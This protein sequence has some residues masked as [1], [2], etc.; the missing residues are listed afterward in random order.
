MAALY[1][2]S[3]GQKV[4]PEAVLE[5]IAELERFDDGMRSLACI[6]GAGGYN[7]VK[8][9]AD[10]LVGKVS[11]GLEMFTASTGGLL[12]KVTAE[13][14]QLRIENE[15]SQSVIDS[16][17]KVLAEIAVA[18]KGEELPLHRHGY[19]DLPELVAVLKLEN[20]LRKATDTCR[21][22][23]GP[24][25]PESPAQQGSDCRSEKP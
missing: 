24:E 13:R 18:L 6:L 21:S 19:Q 11:G 14:N 10:Q 15:E 22:E 1:R 4:T 16:L 2:V 17:A 7:A 23:Q 9:S 20:E 5:M 3:F 12:D 8:L 25:T